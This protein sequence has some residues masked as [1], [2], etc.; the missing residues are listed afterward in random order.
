M[1]TVGHEEPDKWTIVQV[2]R[3]KPMSYAT[4]TFCFVSL[5]VWIIIFL[6]AALE[7][8]M[9][10]PRRFYGANAQQ[11]IPNDSDSEGDISVD[12]CIAVILQE[13]N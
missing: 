7:V 8:V 5:F 2:P 9:I 12:K 4:L 1:T 3:G 10:N 13:K 11:N 6:V